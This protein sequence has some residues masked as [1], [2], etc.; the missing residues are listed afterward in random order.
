M[1][2][3]PSTTLNTGRR[4][5][6]SGRSPSSI[7][8][9]GMASPAERLP[10]NVP[11][12]FYVDRTCIDCDTC[13]RIAP[14]GLRRGRRP[15]VR[16]V[17]ARNG[18]GA[19]PGADGARRL[20]DGFDRNGRAYGRASRRAAA[21]PETVAENVSFCGFTAESSFGAWSYFVERP[22][23]NVLVD[24]PRAA[25]PLLS[26]LEAR[27]GVA[28]LFLTHRDDVADHEA[29]HGRFAC[30]RVLHEDDVTAGTRDVERRLRGTRPGSPRRR[31]ARD[32]DARPHARPRRAALSRTVSLHGRPPRVVAAPRPARRLPRRLLVLLGR[33]DPLHGAPA[34]PPVRVGPSGPRG[35][36]PRVLGRRD[37]DRSRALRRGHA[38]APVGATRWTAARTRAKAR[39]SR[40]R[41][42]AGGLPRGRR[43]TR[44]PGASGPGGERTTTHPPPP[45]PQALPPQAPASRAASIAR[46]MAGEETTGAS[47]RR[48]SHSRRS[49]A[50]MA[51]KS[52]ADAA[53]SI[54]RATAATSS[55]RRATSRSP[56]R[57]ARKISQLFIPDECAAPVSKSVRWRSHS[58]G[59]TSLP[60]GV[61]A[62]RVRSGGR[63]ARPRAAGSS[64]G[65][66]RACRGP[67]SRR[68]ARTRRRPRPPNSRPMLAASAADMATVRADDPPSPEP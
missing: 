46:S 9:D 24:S 55:R 68:R 18:R 2:L 42:G 5:A 43:A 50:P 39:G 34:R 27:G 44:G 12:N 30:E 33:A 47:R 64:P 52:P 4:R 40:P 8:S 29:L 41:R 60:D 10:D 23:G 62:A 61:D 3:E 67:A 14:G 6:T 16:R 13:R 25:G 26:A 56:S 20:P 11:G 49:A 58:E 15:L 51:R 38:A 28:T 19:P 54:S 21:F 48:A 17:A 53:S 31:P 36:A 65:R 66:R 32:P 63:G 1:L 59:S 45:A 37:A 35:M 22:E 57:R 7:G